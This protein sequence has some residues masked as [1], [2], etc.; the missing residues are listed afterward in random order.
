MH[1]PTAFACASLT[2]PVLSEK[3]TYTGTVQLLKNQIPYPELKTKRV[4]RIYSEKWKGK[5][6]FTFIKSDCFLL[7]FK[8]CV[9]YTNT[10][11]DS[12]M[13]FQILAFKN[14]ECLIDCFYFTSLSNVILT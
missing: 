10:H 2:E 14:K 9:L 5:S 8:L 7:F 3:I 1:I 4:P 6:W 12:C 11:T 13:E